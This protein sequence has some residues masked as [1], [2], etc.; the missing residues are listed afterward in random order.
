M[1]T[2]FEYI[3][4]HQKVALTAVTGMAIL[5]FLLGDVM[6]GGRMSPMVMT[7]LIVG[8]F[9]LVG[10]VWGTS[11]GKSSE[12]AIFG[13]VLGLAL[14]LVFMF[15]TR[16]PSAVTATSGNISTS[17]LGEL[18]RIRA[19]ANRMVNLVY[20]ES[21]PNDG[22]MSQIM[23][24]REL[25]RLMFNYGV[26]NQTA[27]VV[28]S[29]LLN[30]EAG[31]L[32]INITDE[33]VMA[34]LK[35]V[36]GSDP[37]GEVK[38]TRQIYFDAI[39]NTCGGYPG[40]TEDT[41]I[42]AIRHE[43]RARQAAKILLGGNRMTP[44]DVWELHRKL[45]T[46]E[47]AQ[48][49]ALPV[50]E[51]VD[52]NVN[53]TDAELAE[54]FNT[55]KGNFPNSTPQGQ[56]EEG[57]PGLYL[58]RRVRLAYVEA[59]YEELEKAAGE[60]TEEEIQKR[61]EE[62][63]SRAMPDI[64]P[65]GEL[66][67]PDLPV[68]PKVPSTP[69]GTT[70]PAAEGTPAE[71]PAESEKPAEPAAE[72][73]AEEKPAEPAA[74]ATEEKPAAP[75]A[76]ESKPAEPAAPAP[77]AKP[78]EPAKKP[79][80]SSFRPRMSGLQ[81]V[82]L[83]EDAP[84]TPEKP[85]EAT[86][87]TPAA[88]AEKPAEPAAP[89]AEEKPAEPA[90]EK[91]AEEKP[92]D[93]KPAEEPAPPSTEQPAGEAPLTVPPVPGD[94][95]GDSDPAPP[96]SK[97]RPLDEAMR[98]EIR[99][100]LLAEKTRPLVEAKINAARDFMSDLHMGVAEYLSQQG[101]K[102]DKTVELSKDA[103]T[104]EEASKRLKEYAEKN[105]L[106]YTETPLLSLQELMQSE[107]HPLG[108]AL[109]GRMG[110]VVDVI[111]RSKAD[112][113]YT[114]STAF[115]LAQKGNYA[116][117]KIEDVAAHEPKSLEEPGV[118]EMAIRAW[119]QFKA[120]PAVEKRAQELADIVSKSD[121]PMAEALTDQT[122]TGVE[123]DKGIFVTVKSTGDF[124][125]LQRSMAPSQFNQDNSPRFGT[126]QGVEGVN[127]KFMEKVF[128]EMKPGATA[129]VPNVDRSIF[130]VMHI[131][132]RTP[133]TEAEVAVMRKQFL[134]S[135]GELTPYAEGLSREYDDSFIDRLFVKHGVKISPAISR[136]EDE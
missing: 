42:D 44:A 125:W 35:E 11:D 130:Y 13:G 8:C 19:L 128:N 18:S 133:S 102:A 134:E 79:E 30:R 91:P 90:A 78:E 85:A 7:S 60:I 22:F 58:P 66:R 12:N 31:Y 67:L 25:P 75:A 81:P 132:K 129:V 5:S 56:L 14:T 112:D 61:Y 115:D 88:E 118:K 59:N 124:S 86:P 113:L 96:T 21:H 73:P 89:A 55:Y 100:E 32:G 41:V 6:A 40:V 103:L 46:R 36:A 37:A 53:P 87:A 62:K 92:A 47:S 106:T 95:A 94:A 54:F 69:E 108:N 38:L 119:R 97:V 33:A 121:K 57:R 105:G 65:H 72:K 23:A 10:W 110:R 17:E 126:I 74:P 9:A 136:D 80:G 43:L 135:Q 70:A 99:D 71:K 45:N 111:S 34:Y 117:W 123:K 20:F 64:N 16:P 48:F 51:F 107:D 29:E 28:L 114:A 4:R 3:R 68:L 2:P 15:M 52:K 82:A 76:E 116:Y 27:E 120:R 127:D 49:V 83:I 63:S 93:A 24:Q 122:V 1:S 39:K 84:A 50:E 109:V 101:D 131:D 104:P 26:P 77:E 98:Q